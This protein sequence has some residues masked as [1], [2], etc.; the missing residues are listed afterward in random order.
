MKKGKR[1]YSEQAIEEVFR[2]RESF[3]VVG[4]TGRIGSGCTSA[5]EIFAKDA[6]SLNL[7]HAAP[8]PHMK[9]RGFQNQQRRADH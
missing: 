3:L 1:A 6:R 9:D 7:P 2:E 5:S 8:V 4:L